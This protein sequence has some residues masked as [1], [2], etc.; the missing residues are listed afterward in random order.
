MGTPCEDGSSS[1]RVVFSRVFVDAHSPP[2]REMSAATIICFA[3][4][5]DSTHNIKT[6]NWKENPAINPR[7]RLQPPTV[8]PPS[9]TSSLV[10]EYQ[11]ASLSC[12]LAL[13][14][15]INPLRNT[16]RNDSLEAQY[17]SLKTLLHFSPSDF[18]VCRCYSLQDLHFLRVHANSHSN[19]SIHTETPSYTNLQR[20]VWLGFGSS[21]ERH[22]FSGLNDSAG[23]VL[24]TP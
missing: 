15:K 5:E 13:K 24:P 12:I 10:R 9:K 6:S 16:L 19:T 4:Q 2:T 7:K 20:E 22:P 23:E 14:A 1:C 11:P 18:H 8:L 17:N 21:L 3:P